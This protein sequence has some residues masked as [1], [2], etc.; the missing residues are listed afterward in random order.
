MSLPDNMTIEFPISD[1]PATTL[2]SEALWDEVLRAAAGS[3]GRLKE[4]SDGLLVD[5]RRRIVVRQWPRAPDGPV[6]KGSP[7]G[8]MAGNGWPL[9]GATLMDFFYVRRIPNVPGLATISSGSRLAAWARHV[10]ELTAADEEI[11]W[12]D[13]EAEPV[14]LHPYPIWKRIEDIERRRGFRDAEETKE[15]N[16]EEERAEPPRTSIFGSM[17]PPSPFTPAPTLQE[18][19]PFHLLPKKLIVHDPDD[20]LSVG[21]RRGSHPGTTRTYKLLLSTEGRA[22]VESDRALAREK[23]SKQGEFLQTGTPDNETGEVPPAMFVT[24]PPAPILEEVAEGHLYLRQKD[25]LGQGNHSV[26]YNAEFELPKDVLAPPVLCDQCL[27]LD[28]R[29]LL[30]E[31]EEADSELAKQT[32]KITFTEHENPSADVTLV[33]A[34]QVEG[35]ASA[36]HR[37]P[38]QYTPA[39]IERRE[40]ARL[41][42]PQSAPS[43]HAL[44]SASTSLTA[45]YTGPVRR[46]SP[47]TPWQH[48]GKPTCAHRMTD[49]ALPSA[50]V[51]VAAKLSLEGDA[52]LAREARNYQAF[53]RHMFE[54][55][56]GYNVLPPLHNPT[57]VGAVVPQF[58][59][60]YVPEDGDGESSSSEEET[61]GGAPD[62]DVKEKRKLKGYLS[63][64]ML[65]ENCGRPIDPRSLNADDRDECAA[66]LYRL[67]ATGYAHGSVF[68]RNIMMQLG[69]LRDPPLFKQEKDRRFRLIDFGR[70]SKSD[71]MSRCRE[72]EEVAQLLRLFHHDD[73]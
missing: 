34:S 49:T 70:T 17:Q 15:A 11:A 56:S 12:A 41:A 66:L 39:E 64:I 28:A 22:K 69:D 8:K 27:M 13:A 47:Q 62:A 40:A 51:S 65:L 10:G 46:V 26:I 29:K 59:G 24:R 55:W 45:T 1:S 23:A 44:S 71:S 43:T 9:W 50:T 6:L 68:E 2:F 5:G 35:T 20:V 18:I 3:P 7:D 63:P 31:Q 67:H 73:D 32:G 58:F 60:Y 38:E 72:E 61:S 54:H 42:N 48:V 14:Q 36:V 21:S 57:P 16:E 4:S 25:A 19:I 37:Y 30:L 52:H 53:P 33:H